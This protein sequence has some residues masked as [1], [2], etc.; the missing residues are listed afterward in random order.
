MKNFLF[1][2]TLLFGFFVLLT[3]QSLFAADDHSSHHDH[4]GHHDHSSHSDG[5]H[6][7]F[8]HPLL[9]EIPLPENKA[10]FD[11]FSSDG[12]EE[13]SHTLQ[14]GFEYAFSDAFGIE[15]ALPFT[16]LSPDQGSSESSFDN[17][18]AALKV[19][20]F[21]FA[22]HGFILSHGLEFVFP[23]G[24]E[25]KGIG[26][27]HEL[28]IAPTLA[29]GYLSG[30]FEFIAFFEFG[31]PTNQREPSEAE[32]ELGFDFSTLYHFSS[33]LA[34]LM[35]LGGESALSGEERGHTLFVLTPGLHITPFEAK[36]LE[37]GFGLSVPL[38][39]EKEFDFRFGLSVFYHF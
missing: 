13:S 35:E 22:D 14:L 11:F 30:R 8:T 9:T 2:I 24:D 18:S 12:E 34:V 20:N 1:G 33:Y 4:S 15:M 16:L 21:A 36:K 37:L 28:E 27:Q 29:L 38:S 17:F 31:I 6:F 26:S 23:T 19:A 32:T 10:R 5:T 3:S 39:D 25:A 7:H